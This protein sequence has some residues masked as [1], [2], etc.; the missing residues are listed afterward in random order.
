MQW[1]SATPDHDTGWFAESLTPLLSFGYTDQSL[2]PGI[3][4]NAETY[5]Y[6]Y[7]HDT[8]GLY[9]ERS[10]G[11]EL[12]LANIWSIRRGHWRGTGEI[13]GDTRGSSI[14]FTMAGYGGVRWDK[15]TVPQATS[16]SR[17]KRESWTVWVDLVSL[18]D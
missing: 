17:V 4:W 2:E 13:D 7:G 12:T 6:S 11:W 16:L 8:S 1:R 3:I 10:T 15:A 14:G 5:D 18:L 9:D